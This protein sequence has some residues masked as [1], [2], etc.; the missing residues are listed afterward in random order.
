M[1]PG[2]R[3]TWALVKLVAGKGIQV[4]IYC[5]F[6]LNPLIRKRKLSLLGLFTAPWT[7]KRPPS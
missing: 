7:R 1:W 5:N 3:S 2:L 4:Q 6:Q